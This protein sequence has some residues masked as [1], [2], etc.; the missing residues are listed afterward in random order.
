[1]RNVKSATHRI[2]FHER[3]PLVNRVR[4]PLRRVLFALLDRIGRTDDAKAIAATTLQGLLNGQHRLV[5][6]GQP[7]TE[8]PYPEL[9]NPLPQRTSHRTDVVLIT[10]RFRSGSTLLWNLFRNIDGVTA[11]Y[12]PLNERRWFDPSRRGER[13][14]RTHRNVADYWREY[15][16]LAELGRYYQER[17][18]DQ[19]L[20]MGSDHWDPLLKRYVEVLVERARGRPVLQFNRVDFRLPWL[21]K[22]FPG[23]RLVHLY[24]HP[25]DQWCSCFPD[26]EYFPA[27]GTLAAFAPYDHYYLLNWVR[28]LR[29]HFPFLEAQGI[30]HPYQLFYLL[31]KL[32]YLFGRQYAHY[33]LAY[34]RLVDQPREEIP[35]L[36]TTLGIAHY[37]LD[38]L[39]ALVDRGAQGKWQ[40][41][42]PDAWFRK[43]E[44]FCESLL[45]DWAAPA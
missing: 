38:R 27:E 37:D 2:P 31:W 26:G 8:F 12:E 10:A 32:S 30:E 39:C 21:R 24:R 4:S 13:I 15:E 44:I 34:E 22:H 20:L 35:R 36:L 3:I 19:Q 9:A 25:R 33:S 43:H 40:K 41:Y 18:I 28:D 45:A 29:Y 5:Q 7:L 42:A 11:Y 17:W 23:A 16:G 1:M 6:V 14:D